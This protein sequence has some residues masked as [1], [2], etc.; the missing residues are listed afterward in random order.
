MDPVL[1][2]SYWKL[3]IFQWS[4]LY[5]INVH[6]LWP[7]WWAYWG[8]L[9]S[10]YGVS[11]ER[12]SF[13]GKWTRIFQDSHGICPY[14]LGPNT[15]SQWTRVL[16]IASLLTLFI[17]KVMFKDGQIPPN[18]VTRPLLLT[19]K[20]NSITVDAWPCALYGR[21]WWLWPV[22]WYWVDTS[23][24]EWNDCLWECSLVFPVYFIPVC[25]SK[26]SILFCM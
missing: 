23:I 8:G 14:S 24:A 16:P 18:C 1:I 3:S 25:A 4:Q 9:T 7:N 10:S 13:E 22:N 12:E 17:P 6:V 11:A 21:F 26:L 15:L 20:V 2:Y 5:F 19:W